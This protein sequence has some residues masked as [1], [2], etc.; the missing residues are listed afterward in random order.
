[1]AYWSGPNGLFPSPNDRAI[2]EGVL[3][4]CGGAE[5][6]VEGQPKRRLRAGAFA[7][8]AVLIGLAGTSASAFAA[9]PKPDPPPVKHVPPP[10]PPADR[11]LRRRR[12]TFGRHRLR[13]P[14]T[15][16]PSGPTAAQIL[17]AKQAAARAKAA[18]AGE[19]AA[20]EEAA[21]AREARAARLA[22]AKRR[23]AKTRK[24][25]AAERARELRG[26]SPQPR[27]VSRSWRR[28]SLD[29]N[30]ADPSRPGADGSRRCSS[31]VS[32][33]SPRRPCPVRACPPCSRSTTV[34]S[35]SSAA[36]SCSASRS[37]PR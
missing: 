32:G 18:D 31:S 22:A 1:M 17:A 3:R 19:G 11:R 34:T 14:L 26:M 35:R 28:F 13:R 20:P 8:T 6:G 33:W 10:P 27:H 30:A 4:R 16:P 15:A 29:E 7:L 9:G 36:W 23:A 5:V 12:P 24:R 2:V 25:A 37:S 21:A